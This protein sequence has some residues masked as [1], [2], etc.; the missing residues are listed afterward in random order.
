MV[1]DIFSL[2]VLNRPTF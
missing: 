2:F 1:I